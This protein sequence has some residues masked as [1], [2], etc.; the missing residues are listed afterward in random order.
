M[1]NKLN[2]AAK[3]DTATGDVEAGGGAAEDDNDAAADGGEPSAAVLPDAVGRGGG[4]LAQQN[5]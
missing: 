3:D 1:I 2:F 5:C 4:V